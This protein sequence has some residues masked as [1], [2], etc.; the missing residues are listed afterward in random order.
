MKTQLKTDNFEITLTEIE[1][2]IDNPTNYEICFESTLTTAYFASIHGI[3]IANKIA[4][5]F[6]NGDNET[7]EFNVAHRHENT[8]YCIIKN[9]RNGCTFDE[10]D[11]ATNQ[12]GKPIIDFIDA[13]CKL[14]NIP[15][16][17]NR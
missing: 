8:L 5:D 9:D 17:P 12:F 11:H 15:F 6:C 1:I 2:D 7:Y 14:L 4:N 13:H 10:I 16:Y 3:E